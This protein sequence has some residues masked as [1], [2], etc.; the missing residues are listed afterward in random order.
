MEII[1]E[2][3]PVTGKWVVSLNLDGY[4][5][6]VADTRIGCALRTVLNR[7]EYDNGPPADST[8]RIV[9]EGW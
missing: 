6:V 3:S 9:V 1:A 2:K 8:V 5:V 4:N 7:F